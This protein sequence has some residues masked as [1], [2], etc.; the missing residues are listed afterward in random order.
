MGSSD[1][2]DRRT[3]RG[4]GEASP[5]SGKSIPTSGDASRAG[6]LSD[7]GPGAAASSQPPAEGR[8]EDSE[9]ALEHDVAELVEKARERDEYLTLAQ[10]TQADFE[11]YRKRAAKEMAAAESRGVAKLARELLPALDNLALALA[12][13]ERAGDVDG[14]LVEGIRLVHNDLTAALARVGIEPYSPEG[15]RFDP[16]EHEAM[17][18]RPVEGAESGTVVEVYQQGYRANGSVLRPA[19]VVVAE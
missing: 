12:A 14:Q 13:A 16:A 2:N 17:A 5:A 15:E 9:A 10:R 8:A 1:S 11:N 19:R 4:A 6:P 7:P 3:D 18:Q